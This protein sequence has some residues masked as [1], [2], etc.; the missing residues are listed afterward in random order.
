LSEIAEALSLSPKTV[1]VYRARILEK[2]RLS[3]NAEIT[4]YALKNGL[5]K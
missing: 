4:H 3:S 2:M 1:S 5:V